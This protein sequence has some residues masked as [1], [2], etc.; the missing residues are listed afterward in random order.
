MQFF[1]QVHTCYSANPIPARSPAEREGQTG[2]MG[3]VEG[4]REEMMARRRRRGRGMDGW[5]GGFTG[6]LNGGDREKVEDF[7][8]VDSR[9]MFIHEEGKREK[10]SNYSSFMSGTV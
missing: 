10:W 9:T 1:I 7:G 5:R 2:K 3:R 4:G 6:E 8:G